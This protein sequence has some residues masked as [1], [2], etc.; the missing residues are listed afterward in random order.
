MLYSLALIILSG[1][2][3]QLFCKKLN[4]PSL[5]GFILAGILLGPAVL[6]VLDP[7]LLNISADIRQIVLIIILTRAGLSLDLRDLK[8]VG[9]PAILLS[10]VP[11]TFE[12]IGVII[13]APLL[14]GISLIDA[15]ILGTVLGAVSPAVVVPRM[16]TLINNQFGTKKGIPQLVL[17][18]SSVDDIYALVL[19]SSF[20]SLSQSGEFNLRNLLALPF[21]ILSGVLV[22][23]LSGYLLSLLFE[24]IH[25][26]TIIQVL[27]LLSISF[28]LVSI[29]DTFANLPFSGILAVMSLAIMLYR[30]IPDQA[31]KVS[32]LYNTLWIPGEIFLFVLVGASVNIQYAFTAGLLPILVILFALSIRMIGTWLSLIGTDFNSKEKGFTLIAYLPKATV[33]AAIGGVPL[34]MGIPTGELILTMS[35]LAILI[36]APLGAFGIDLSYPRLLTD[37][38]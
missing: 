30:Q 26:D 31:E 17:A 20:L 6:N 16:I 3:I 37:D 14:L 11:A 34:A 28:V 18:G 36:T 8:K 38:S 33:Q 27:I 21:S 9:R 4:I 5:I 22:G 10:F 29:E 32:K 15:A 35:V 25:L 19:F 1:I 23:F 7:T 13:F 12:I 24:K 2:F